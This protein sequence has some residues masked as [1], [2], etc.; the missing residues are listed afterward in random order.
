MA[1]RLMRPMAFTSGCLA[2]L[3]ASLCAAVSGPARAAGRRQAAD[4]AVN[5]AQQVLPRSLPAFELPMLP[6]RRK[7][8]VSK[9]KPAK[10]VARTVVRA[11]SKARPARKAATRATGSRSRRTLAPSRR[12]VPSPS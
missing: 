2:V 6:K 10:R 1:A 3:I 7:T 8:A 9:A 5:F 4:V 12:R 11:T